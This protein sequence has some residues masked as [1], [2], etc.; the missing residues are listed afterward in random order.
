MTFRHTASWLVGL[1]GLALLRA[2]AGDGDASEAFV[3]ARLAEIERIL[4][5]S[6]RGEFGDGDNAVQIDA[7]SG[8]AEWAE[9]YDSEAN[10][11][12][13]VEQQTV[14]KI[15]AGIPVGRAVDAACGTGRHSKTL[16]QLGHSVTGVDSSPQML[17][18]ARIALP[19]ATFHEGTLTAIPLADAS[20]DLLVCSLVLTHVPDLRP[21]FAEFARVLAPGGQLVT[22]DLHM[23]S[24]Y[25]G[26]AASVRL[27]DGRIGM[28]P[29]HRWPAS[30]YLSAAFGS[31]FTVR[32][33]YEPAWPVSDTAGGPTARAWCPDA[34]DAAYRDF[35]AAIIWHFQRR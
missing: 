23:F 33:C 8:Y 1:E 27:A 24:L 20:A 12:I 3:M 9:S 28:L 22:S 14:D 19:S 10:P 5:A 6:K 11:L 2:H 18:T 35:P 16:V 21:V 17:A 29:A 30:A 31:G 4:A 26:G 13:A 32:A 34:T 7:V 15:L 25:L